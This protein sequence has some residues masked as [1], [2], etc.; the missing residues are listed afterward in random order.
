MKCIVTTCLFLVFAF[1]VTAQDVEQLII[2]QD[3]ENFWQAYDKIITTKDSIQQHNYLKTLFLDKGTP[4]LTAIMMVRNYTAQSYIDAINNYPQFWTSIRQNTFKAKEFASDIEADIAKIR[5]IYPHLKPAKLY[6]T[7]GAFRTGGT[8]LDSMVLIGS[9][10]AMADESTVTTEFPHQL[11]HLPT[12]YKTNPIKSVSFNNTHEYIHTQQKTTIGNTLLAQCLIEGVAEFVTV[13][14]TGKPSMAPALTVG[15]NNE[16]RVR[17]ILTRQLFNSFTDFWFYSNAD[18]EFNVRDLGYYAGYA[19]CEKYYNQ[20]ADKLL[21]I[22]EMIE[23][24]YNNETDLLKFVDQSGYFTKPVNKI[25]KQ[26]EKTQPRV[27]AIKEFKNGATNVSAGI[28]Q[29]TFTFSEPMDDRY[30]SF[31]LGP[32]GEN[33][34]LR[35]TKFLGFTADK[36]SVS[37]EIA[38]KPN[39][40]YQIIIGSGFR[41]G[42]TYPV[43]LQPYLVNFTTVAK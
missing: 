23:L 22:K 26:F 25:K 43:S 10:I 35:L 24:D 42:T 36:K 14:G 9:E 16:G 40:Q 20:A 33:N 32:L 17:E 29:I 7:M 3:V 13:L 30:R 12:Y 37:F 21:A 4:G 27:T 8:T 19:I 15:K 1:K 28:T 39:Q 38:L 6:F 18:N 2:S 11:A 5:N 34:L 31:E 41:S